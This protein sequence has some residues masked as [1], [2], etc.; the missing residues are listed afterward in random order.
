VALSRRLLPWAPAVLWAS[1]IFALSAQS[2]PPQ[3]PGTADIPFIDKF[4][5]LAAYGILGALLWVALRRTTV[6]GRAT[7]AA[8]DALYAVAIA[9]FY[10]LTDEIHQFFVLFRQADAADLAFDAL[11]A[12][13]VVLAFLLLQRRGAKGNESP[14]KG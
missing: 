9:S 6:G 14:A 13:L 10:G 8:R 4:E 11:G 1:V 5:H 12:A 2:H 7:S 3:P